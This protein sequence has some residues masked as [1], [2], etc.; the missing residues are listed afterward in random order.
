MAHHSAHQAAHRYRPAPPP[1]STPRTVTPHRIISRGLRAGAMFL[2]LTHVFL[3]G[4]WFQEGNVF[5]GVG[6][7]VLGIGIPGLLMLAEL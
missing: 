4:A 5:L 3:G 7:I 1:P 2:G 6:S